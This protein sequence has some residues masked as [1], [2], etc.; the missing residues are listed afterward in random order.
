MLCKKLVLAALSVGFAIAAT[1]LQ[2][3]TPQIRLPE[4]QRSKIDISEWK[5]AQGLLTI[6][7]AIEASAVSLSEVSSQLRVPPELTASDSRRVRPAMKKGEKSVFLHIF[8]IKPD[9]A[10]WFEVDLRA[11]PAQKELIELIKA[12]HAAEP[13]TCKILETE[14]LTISQPLFIG[15]SLPLL[16]RDDIAICTAAETAF[17]PDF[18]SGDQ[19]FYIWY[20][21][22]GFGKGLSAEILKAFSAAV[23]SGNIKSSESTA[24][25]LIRKLEA[26]KE[27]LLL[28]KAGDENFAIPAA[29]A[30]ELIKANLLTLRA[31]V[32][33]S[34]DELEK[35]LK[36]MK[37]GYTKPFLMFNLGNLYAGLKKNSK[38]KNWFEQALVEIEAWPLAEKKLKAL[39]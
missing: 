13:V 15:S 11:M 22:T 5:P 39:K 33:K 25:M 9:F 10:G 34:P 29:V 21:A 14:A 32:N 37:P 24:D 20:P 3:M 6:R 31:I 7:V 2:A 12:K 8:N 28:E 36:D 27:P 18:K 4:W 38:A 30:I 23:S 17:R 1:G 19:E 26:T 35:V 16:V